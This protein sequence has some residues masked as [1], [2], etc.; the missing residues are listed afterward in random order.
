MYMHTDR[1]T[2][3]FHANGSHCSNGLVESVDIGFSLHSTADNVFLLLRILHLQ[4]VPSTFI[5]H[6][7]KTI[8][9]STVNVQNT[10]LFEQCRWT[11]YLRT[12][13]VITIY[14]IA[15]L[16]HSTYFT[17]AFEHVRNRNFVENVFQSGGNLI[18]CE[19]T[20]IAF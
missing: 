4:C 3:T 13:H 16:T 19:V 2:H 20:G 18:L 6:N 12:C 11:C 17:S 10:A 15:F 9:G 14:P 1:Q 8:V 7:F 5:N